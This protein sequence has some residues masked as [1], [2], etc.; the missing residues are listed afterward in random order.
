MTSSQ[1]LSHN[2]Q[3]EQP[4]QRVASIHEGGINRRTAVMRVIS[5]VG[6][7]VAGAAIYRLFNRDD[8]DPETERIM[9]GLEKHGEDLTKTS[10]A[11]FKY[12]EDAS[13]FVA[14]SVVPFMSFLQWVVLREDT[15]RLQDV[16]GSVADDASPAPLIRKKFLK[17][18]EATTLFQGINPA[19]KKRCETLYKKLHAFAQQFESDA[20]RLPFRTPIAAPVPQGET[21][22]LDSE[23][24]RP[25]DD[26]TPLRLREF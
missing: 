2:E 24:G 13:S 10:L 21:E 20:K 8:M 12:L 23:S 7:G 18:G 26:S 19:G 16:D 6:A 15:G 25:L 22:S 14:D 17:E 9:S 11:Q 1:G 4:D 3:F 5:M